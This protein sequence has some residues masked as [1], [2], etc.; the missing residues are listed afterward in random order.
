M[1]EVGIV[2][3]ISTFGGITFTVNTAVNDVSVILVGTPDLSVNGTIMNLVYGDNL[4]IEGFSFN[5]PYQF[6]QGRINNGGA[7]EPAFFQ[8][9]W[10]DANGHNAS[11]PE[12]GDTG[13]INIPDANYWYETFAF[14]PMPATVDI[15]YHLEIIGLGFEVSMFN[16][17][18]V[19]NE[20]VLDCCIH[21]KVRHTLALIA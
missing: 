18:A 9:G 1:N 21:L 15:K 8:L 16:V 4:T 20:E 14:V 10:R 13:R 6:G 19:L 11:V 12:V 2:S 5:C 3:R 7:G 17:P